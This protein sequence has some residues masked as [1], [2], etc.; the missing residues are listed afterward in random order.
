MF[1]DNC[2]VDNCD[3]NGALMPGHTLVTD[4][5][6]TADVIYEKPD[7]T[8]VRKP[9]KIERVF[10]DVEVRLPDEEIRAAEAKRQEAI[11]QREERRLARL[12]ARELKKKTGNALNS[13]SDSEKNESDEEPIPCVLE[14]ECVQIYRNVRVSGRIPISSLLSD[15]LVS[16]V[17]FI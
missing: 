8:I 9:R 4:R 16:D 1:P 7:G 11:R 14:T 6:I 13:S 5:D 2:A 15:T 10:Y 12:T 17:Q 3:C